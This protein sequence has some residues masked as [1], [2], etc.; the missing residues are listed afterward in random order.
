VTNPCMTGLYRAL[1]VAL[2]SMACSAAD[3]E[4]GDALDGAVERPEPWPR[5]DV[6]SDLR[7]VLTQAIVAPY[8]DLRNPR[9]EVALE[10]QS[11]SRAY[12]IVLPADGSATGWREPRAGFTV[13]GAVQDGDFVPVRLP[14]YAYCGVFDDEWQKDVRILPPGERIRFEY[15]P[16]Y[17]FAENDDLAKVRIVAHYSYGEHARDLSKVPRALHSMPSYALESNAIELDVGRP[18]GL[19][20]RLKGEWPEDPAAPLADYFEAL[21]ENRSADALPYDSPDVGGAFL[22]FEVELSDGKRDFFD[23]GTHVA[24]VARESIL[25]G[26]TKS[27]LG[28]TS[29]I[30]LGSLFPPREKVLRFRAQYH[31]YFEDADTPERRAAL[32]VNER[33]LRSDWVTLT[34]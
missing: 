8:E 31:V 3:L 29:R 25:P 19:V 16:F 2:F 22:T 30:G 14:R 5:A 24:D 4:A 1:G 32:G 6:E 7:L 21:L 17:T 34:R 13:E 20:L 15:F 18:Y 26:E 11:P 27:L 12:A 33:A 10:N 9:L 28:P 23:L